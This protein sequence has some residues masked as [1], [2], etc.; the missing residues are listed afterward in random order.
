M[1]TC[2]KDI[3]FETQFMLV[4][5]KESSAGESDGAT[6]YTVFLPL[7]EG[8]FRAVLQG[9]DKNEL[10]IFLESGDNA[11]ETNQGISL[12]YMHAGTN[13]FEVINHVVK[14]VEQHLQTFRH[15]EKKKTVIVLGEDVNIKD[16]DIFNEYLVLELKRNGFPVMCS[17]KLPIDGSSKLLSAVEEEK[18]EVAAKPVPELEKTTEAASVKPPKAEECDEG[19]DEDGDLKRVL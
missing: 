1:G 10:E 8:P 9:N 18:K 11:V 17:I 3:P 2:G 14:A 19:E 4:E 6:I 16:I 13:P 5:S 15:R 12:V 7:L